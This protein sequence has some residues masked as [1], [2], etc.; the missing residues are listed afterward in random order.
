MKNMV[1]YLTLALVALFPSIAC[2]A[3]LGVSSTTLF[4]FEQRAFPGFAKQTVVPATQFLG[5]D[6]DKRRTV[7][8]SPG[9][10]SLHSPV[11]VFFAASRLLKCPAT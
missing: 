9:V 3:D 7:R 8:I 5:A 11:D 4:R 6:L 1:H 2:A 10:P